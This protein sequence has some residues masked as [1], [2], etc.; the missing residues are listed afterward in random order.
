LF[1][2]VGKGIHDALSQLDEVQ[3]FNFASN[4]TF[5]ALGFALAAAAD[6]RIGS[7][8]MGGF[9]ALEVRA[10]YSLFI[11]QDGLRRNIYLFWLGQSIG[12]E[13]IEVAG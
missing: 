1:S 7:C 3:F 10:M 11:A 2:D 6:L 4:Q 13:S 12:E 9:Q 5:V 8:P